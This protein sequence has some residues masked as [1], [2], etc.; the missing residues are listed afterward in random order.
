MR[1]LHDQIPGSPE[2]IQKISNGDFVLLWG[3]KQAIFSRSIRRLEKL[4]PLF[5]AA[6]QSVAALHNISRF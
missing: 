2:G 5:N 1:V 6:T 3:V 4:I